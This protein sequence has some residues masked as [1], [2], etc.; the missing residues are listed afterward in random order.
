LRRATEV[1]RAA[2]TFEKI[3]QHYSGGYTFKKGS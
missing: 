1:L 2:G 3:L